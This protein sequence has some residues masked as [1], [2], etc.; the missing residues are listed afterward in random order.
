M[1]K[2]NG[3]NV[4]DSSIYLFDLVSG[5]TVISEVTGETEEGDIL[6]LYR[7]RVL[8]QNINPNG[9]MVY[10]M[11]P[12]LSDK[13]ELV[14]MNVVASTSDI[15]RNILDAYLQSTTGLQVASAMPDKGMSKLM[16]Q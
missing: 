13:M 7:P 15:P 3:H 8:I 1:E 16:R 12:W 11:V 10:G 9:D 6:E 14:T 2:L 4:L 5:K